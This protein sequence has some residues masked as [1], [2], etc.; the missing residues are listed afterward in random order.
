MATFPCATCGRPAA[1]V[2]VAADGDGVTVSGFLGETWYSMAPT[3]DLLD[4]IARGDAAALR[5]A[6]VG[7]HLDLASFLCVACGAVYC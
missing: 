2:T 6:T 5:R 1:T 7:H 3:T 4:A